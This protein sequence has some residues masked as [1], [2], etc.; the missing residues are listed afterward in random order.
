MSRGKVGD[1]VWVPDQTAGV[2]NDSAVSISGPL[3]GLVKDIHPLTILVNVHGLQTA[4]AVVDR[5]IYD[6]GDLYD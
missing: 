5:D 3:L 1:L 4:V 2:A 6:I